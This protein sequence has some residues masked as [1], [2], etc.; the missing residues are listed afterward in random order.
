MDQTERKRLRDKYKQM[1]EDAGYPE[2]VVPSPWNVPTKP[3]PPMA[4]DVDIL[5][6]RNETLP[7]EGG[8][9]STTKEAK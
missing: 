4:E 1:C 7:T 8:F 2:G 5:L 9:F 3:P 6:E